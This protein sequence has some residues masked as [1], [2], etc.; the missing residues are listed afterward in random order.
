M[1]IHYALADGLIY[2]LMYYVVRYRRKIVAMN[3]SKAFPD[4]TEAERKQIAKGFY[5]QFCHTIVESLYGFRMT[6]EEM[7]QHV[8]FEGMDEVNRLID[9]AGGGIFMLAHFGNWEWM[10]SIQQWLSEA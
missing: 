7:R 10:A 3:L 2:P 9:A 4:K 5:R 8:V 6:D 1:R